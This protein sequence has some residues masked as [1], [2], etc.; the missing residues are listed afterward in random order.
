MHT[1]KLMTT[2]VR[3]LMF[4]DDLVVV[5]ESGRD[6]QKVLQ[7]LEEYCTTWSLSINVE[8]TNIV[9]WSPCDHGTDFKYQERR[10]E[11]VKSSN[12]TSIWD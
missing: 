9:R 10:V 6:L 5:T 7:A 11:Q 12:L 2:D 1:I 8:K 4:A 3:W